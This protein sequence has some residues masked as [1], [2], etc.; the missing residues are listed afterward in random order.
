MDDRTEE[1]KFDL[2]YIY[3]LPWERETMTTYEDIENYIKGYRAGCDKAISLILDAKVDVEKE[4]KPFL[5][6]R[7]DKSGQADNGS[8]EVQ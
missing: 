2:G 8:I 7:L 5:M 6:R 3:T 4:L 1:G